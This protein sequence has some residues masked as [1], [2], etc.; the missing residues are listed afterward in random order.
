MV[1]DSEPEGGCIVALIH[2]SRAKEAQPSIKVLEAH[3]NHNRPEP[4]ALF[5]A[6]DYATVQK[7]GPSK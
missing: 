7:G 3:N 1:G 4:S 5:A 2:L 6:V